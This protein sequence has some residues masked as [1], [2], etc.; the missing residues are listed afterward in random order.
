MQSFEALAPDLEA[1]SFLSEF[2]ALGLSPYEARV[3]LALLRLGPANSA[4]LARQS[5]VPRT[6]TYQVVEELNRKGLAQRLAVDGPALWTCPGRDDVFARLDA[7]EE[8]RLR[9]HRARS[10]RLREKLAEALPDGPSLAGPYVHIV[11]VASQVGESYNR[12]LAHAEVEFLVFNRPP[13]SVPPDDV[14]SAVLECVGRGVETRALYQ[15]E[16]WRQ[17]SA[18]AF[19]DV[20]RTYHQAGVQGA[21]VG[22]LP[23]KMAIADRKIALLTMTD[24]VLPEVGFPTSLLVEHPGFASLMADAFNA[25]WRDAQAIEEPVHVVRHRSTRTASRSR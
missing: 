19:R 23:M 2:E 21:L 9:Q 14:N 15:A 18:A 24:P 8:E 22:E 11:Q 13:Y 6:S 5:G 10:V 17:A 3:L 7:V 12:L 16:Q 25:R 20:M 1:D 4:Q